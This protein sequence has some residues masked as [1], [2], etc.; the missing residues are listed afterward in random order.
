MFRVQAIDYSNEK[1]ELKEYLLYESDCHAKNWTGNELNIISHIEGKYMQ[2]TKRLVTS[3]PDATTGKLETWYEKGQTRVAHTI[4]FT[5]KEVDKILF[6]EHP[7]G[8]DAINITDPSKVI[9]YGKFE[10]VLGVPS[11]RCADFTYEQFIEPEWKKFV[12][13][14]IRPG[15]PANRMPSWMADPVD[16]I[17]SRLID[18]VVDKSLYTTD[19]G[20]RRLIDN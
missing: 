14:A 7:F 3:D 13:L 20:T 19:Y 1:K 8:L 4:P 2:Q 18:D 10:H 16:F 11:F 6:G 5:K 9:F 12:E 17:N 15:G